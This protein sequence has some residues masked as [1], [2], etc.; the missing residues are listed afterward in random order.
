MNI[1]RQCL[2]Y[3]TQIQE[4]QCLPHSGVHTA[5]HATYSK[6]NVLDV[7]ADEFS[8]YPAAEH[9]DPV[10]YFLWLLTRDQ[11]NEQSQLCIHRSRPIAD[12]PA[13]G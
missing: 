7:P 5:V 6:E 10:D 13:H 11:L 3:C 8:K 4:D 9:I 12:Y 1:V 2:S